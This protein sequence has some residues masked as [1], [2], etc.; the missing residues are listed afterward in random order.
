MNKKA[1]RIIA[2][3]VIIAGLSGVSYAGHKECHGKCDDRRSDV[4]NQMWKADSNRWEG[5][6]N[7]ANDCCHAC[8][9]SKQ[10]HDDKKNC[11]SCT[12]PE[13]LLN[14]SDPRNLPTP[15]TCPGLISGVVGNC[16]TIWDA[17]TCPQVN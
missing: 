1:L 17:K 8:C 7:Y 4:L 3:V 5:V 10:I 6:A 13:C 15:A 9:N 14:W 16:P 11:P 2:A 12:M